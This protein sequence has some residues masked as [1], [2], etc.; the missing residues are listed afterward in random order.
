MTEV[1]SYDAKVAELR[2]IFTQAKEERRRIEHKKLI[3]S[4]E[5]KNRAKSKRKQERKNKKAGRR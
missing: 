5:K 1:D 3:K 2:S 4:L